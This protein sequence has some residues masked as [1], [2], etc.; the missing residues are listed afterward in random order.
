MKRN[1]EPSGAICTVRDSRRSGG[2]ASTV[3]R[4]VKRVNAFS[5]ARTD[6]RMV[7]GCPIGTRTSPGTTCTSIKDGKI[8]IH[9]V[10]AARPSIGAASVTAMTR[11]SEAGACDPERPSQLSRRHDGRRSSDSRRCT[12]AATT[13]SRKSPRRLAAIRIHGHRAHQHVVEWRHFWPLRCAFFDEPGRLPIARRATETPG[14]HHK[15]AERDQHRENRE[16]GRG[17]RQEAKSGPRPR[18]SAS[19]A[20]AA[21]ADVR[22][23]ARSTASTRHRRRTARRSERRRSCGVTRD[24][25]PILQ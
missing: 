13:S 12:A 14:S 1:P 23:S 4:G 8:A 15:R 19:N 22:P 10:S 17:A 3:S 16:K 18:P 9:A 6:A 2:P 5:P 24:L 25:Q 7:T 20:A 11:L 21:T